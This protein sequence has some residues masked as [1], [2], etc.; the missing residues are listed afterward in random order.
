MKNCARHF[1][2]QAK[3]G[4]KKHSV[5]NLSHLI[6]SYFFSMTHFS[7]MASQVQASHITDCFLISRGHK[8]FLLLLLFNAQ[9]GR[10]SFQKSPKQEQYAE[11]W[12]DT[13]F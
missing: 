1:S 3:K 7:R 10:P 9:N 8:T 4:K 2:L 11:I 12:G 5:F 13:A 6:S